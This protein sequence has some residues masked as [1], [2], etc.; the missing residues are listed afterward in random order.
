MPITVGTSQNNQRLTKEFLPDGTKLSEANVKQI[1][2]EIHDPQTPKEL[3][4][5]FLSLDY[6]QAI[7]AGVH[8][9][10]KPKTS[11]RSKDNFVFDTPWIPFD[12]DYQ[13]NH[14][15]DTP[16]TPY[17]KL[18]SDIDP[19]F[20][21]VS[22][23]LKNSASNVIEHSLDCKCTQDEMDPNCK[24][25]NPHRQKLWVQF[26]P[27]TTAEQLTEYQ[28]R[29]FKKA[30]IK[31]YV[32]AQLSN[33]TRAAPSLLHRTLFD[34]SAFQT[35]AWA[36][37]AIP[38]THSP[39]SHNTHFEEHTGD[40]QYIDTRLL[41]LTDAE[42]RHYYQVVQNIKDEFQPLIKEK[43]QLIRQEHPEQDWD[44][45][46]IGIL[47]ED[48]IL[49]TTVDGLET[50]IKVQ[51][52]T[53]A[54]VENNLEK[55]QHFSSLSY[56]DPLDPDYGDD[57]AKLYVNISDNALQSVNLH[58]FAHGSHYFRILPNIIDI[59]Q[60][61][62]AR[63]C[64]T[65]YST[66]NGKKKPSKELAKSFKML[67]QI[68]PL[69]YAEDDFDIEKAVGDLKKLGSMPALRSILQEQ[70]L[71]KAKVKKEQR[72]LENSHPLKPYSFLA[73]GSGKLVRYDQEEGLKGFTDKGAA[74]FLANKDDSLTGQELFQ[75]WLTDPT[76]EDINGFG[77]YPLNTKGKLNMWGGFNTLPMSQPQ[78][79]DDIEPFLYFINTLT[80]NDENGTNYILDWLADIVQNPLRDT[81]MR[82]AIILE[83]PEMGTGK[84]TFAEFIK[85]FFHPVN[86]LEVAKLS[87]IVG[88]FNIR[89][90]PLVFI[91]L[92]EVVN[93][94]NMQ[95]NAVSNVLKDML[96]NPVMEVEQKGIDSR[97]VPNRLHTLITT[98]HPFIYMPPNDRRFT[99]FKVS[100]VHAEDHEYFGQLR[101]WWYSQNGRE[102]VFTYLLHRKYDEGLIT[103]S[104]KGMDTIDAAIDRLY[105]IEA[106]V[107]FLLTNM[108]NQEVV[109]TSG[110]L[111]QHY[112]SWC[113]D[114]RIPLDKRTTQ[115]KLTKAMK[116]KYEGIGFRFHNNKYLLNIPHFRDKFAQV[117]L[118]TKELDWSKYTQS[119]DVE[120]IKE[121]NIEV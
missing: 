100:T 67:K 9:L 65:D 82:T 86:T 38:I 45:I 20:A 111:Y 18:L 121:D 25:V 31:G 73:E 112:D 118:N 50:K 53:E 19:Q 49:Y 103:T 47:T 62:H 7:I 42:E 115:A 109:L 68:L 23:L 104:Y 110:E 32:A 29:L 15:D 13:T 87:R 3:K 74:L 55:L 66:N 69:F 28:H 95:P 79:N 4:E 51:D 88:Q 35:Q 26:K 17:I 64:I 94:T 11:K 107:F 99:I 34:Q 48:T 43:Q 77:L 119:M 96:G 41:T 92:N 1:N 116:A 21:H 76:R 2:L 63:D 78:H 56:K 93:D 6:N 83:S 57:K 101:D 102:K 24:L 71:S 58:S 33:S 75:E 40:T 113:E 22:Y 10:K 120:Q 14:P 39:Y 46:E 60:A 36:Y 12:R 54:I 59:E 108:D 30:Y 97:I 114:T 44:S 27:G 91:V 89:L 16:S 90:M 84:S 98:N 61:L 105:N 37:E 5:L 85:S 80:H 52:I 106:W 81:D 72:A 70:T 117:T 8:K